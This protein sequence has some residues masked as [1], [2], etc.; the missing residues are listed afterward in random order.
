MVRCPSKLLRSIAT[1]SYYPLHVSHWRPSRELPTA[2]VDISTGA[3]DYTRGPED[4]HC[5]RFSDR[6]DQQRD[7]AHTSVGVFSVQFCRS[8][9]KTSC[10]PMPGYA[11][12]KFTHG[13]SCRDDSVCQ[14]GSAC[15]GR[16]LAIVTQSRRT[17]QWKLLILGLHLH[18][19]N[20]MGLRAA[21]IREKAR[22]LKASVPD[23]TDLYS[24]TLSCGDN[25]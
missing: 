23:Y 3:L 7:Y 8:R 12:S 21:A 13:G 19:R 6:R 22:I 10:D 24:G 17:G 9:R 25:P 15:S 14:S 2:T 16:A 5:N 11:T 1:G 18:F 20:P 4:P